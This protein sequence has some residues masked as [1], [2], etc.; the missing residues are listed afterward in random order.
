MGRYLPKYISWNKVHIVFISVV[1]IDTDDRDV[2]PWISTVSILTTDKRS[3]K[4]IKSS[5]QTDGEIF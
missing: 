4:T 1:A 2:N 5:N 3:N